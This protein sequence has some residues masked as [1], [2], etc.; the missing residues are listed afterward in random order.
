[1][2]SRKFNQ[3]VNFFMPEELKFNKT[4]SRYQEF[5]TVV[6]SVLIGLPLMLM[7]PLVIYWLNRPVLGY[8]LN[9]AMVMII[10]ISVKYFNHYRIPMTFTAVITY[11]IIYEW[12]STTGYIY[13][14]NIAVLHMYLLAAV[15]ADKKYGALAIGGN[16]T[17]LLI[18][19]FQTPQMGLPLSL[20][21]VLGEPLYVLL[22]NCLITIFFGGF[23]A[24]L[25]MDQE[26]DR[27][28]IKSL[29][30]QRIDELD[31]AVK[32][33]TEQLDTMRENIATDFHD[34]TGNMLS[35]ITRQA[36][37]L[38]LKLQPGV[39]V[40]KIV[41]SIIFNSKSLYS[42]S[43]DFLW[44]L[45]HNSDDAEELFKYLTAYGQFYYNQFDIA[46]SSKSQMKGNK[47]LP[48]SSALNLIY[49]FKEAMNN[50]V[51]HS[52]ANEVTFEMRSE[53]STII[54][55]LQDDGQWKYYDNLQNHYGLA[56]M[57][58]RCKK[59]GFNKRI[60]KESTGTRLEIIVP[61]MILITNDYE[62]KNNNY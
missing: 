5:R 15:W 23:L 30:D 49:I 14:S 45:N 27:A 40:H 16:L 59:N 26:R 41:D 9:N 43:K 55:A 54:F 31:E 57:A 61:L 52:G 38:K 51:K 37:Q 13:S 21:S 1:M 42:S 22:L 2:E 48:P 25:Q 19:Y 11:F 53:Q 6:T 20:E 8:L 35:A 36:T 60:Y 62:K 17:V 56:N 28:K 39:E 46:F 58:S 33:R 24:Y 50:V 3:L 29:Q 4:S 32:K 47:Q 44:H 18:I 10:L 7:F 12:I 34:E